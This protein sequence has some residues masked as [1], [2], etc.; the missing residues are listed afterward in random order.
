VKL[1][2]AKLKQLKDKKS[3][4]I[5]KLKGNLESEEVSLESAATMAE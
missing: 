1:T 5:K 4:L 2:K 3:R